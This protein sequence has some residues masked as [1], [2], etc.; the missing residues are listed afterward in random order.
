MK[1]PRYFDEEKVDSILL[2]MLIG[3]YILKN[4]LGITHRD[5]KPANILITQQG[6]YCLSDFG[7]SKCFE[8]G[9]INTS[10]NESFL[11]TLTV[12]GT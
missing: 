3:L 1:E 9:G 7:V 8:I 6:T 2:Q 10:I 4:K 5:I 11:S 12:T